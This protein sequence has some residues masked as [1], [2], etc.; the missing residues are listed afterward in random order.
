MIY[1]NV[2]LISVEI[3]KSNRPS[4]NMYASIMCIITIKYIY[5]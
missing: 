2:W 3:Y 4:I 1:L 5:L